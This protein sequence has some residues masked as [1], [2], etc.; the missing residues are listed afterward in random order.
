MK[1]KSF[2]FLCG[3]T[4]FA[5]LIRVG[6]TQWQGMN[7]YESSGKGS[8]IGPLLNQLRALLGDQI[9]AALTFTLAAYVAYITIQYCAGKIK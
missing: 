1:K 4:G 7:V 8:W 5:L 9:S 3:L 6:I 2:I